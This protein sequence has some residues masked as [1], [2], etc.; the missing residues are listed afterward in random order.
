MRSAW[1]LAASIVSCAALV[2]P[3]VAQEARQIVIADGSLAEAIAALSRQTGVSIGTLGALPPIKVKGFSARLTAEQALRRILQGSGYIARPVARGAYRIER[4]PTASR[5]PARRPAP[6][7][8]PLPPPSEEVLYPDI[9]VTA[10]KREAD[11]FDLPYSISTILPGDLAGTAGHVGTGTIVAFAN[12]INKTNMGPGRNRLFI[13][14]VADSP[15]NGPSQSTVAL[16]LGDARINFDAPDPHLSLV[17]IARVEVLKGPQGPLY[18]TG[19]LGGIYRVVPRA[20]DPKATSLQL[21]TGLGLT[22]GGAISHASDVVANLPIGGSLAMRGVAYHERSGGWIDD[23][24]R[25]RENV[26]SVQI[27]GGRLALQ[28]TPMDWRFELNGAAQVLRAADS[29][30]A[31]VPQG[32]V[33]ETKVAEPHTGDFALAQAAAERDFGDV[34]LRFNAAYVRHDYTNQFDATPSSSI[35][36]GEPIQVY[37]EKRDSTLLSQE[38][39]LSESH[40]RFQWLLGVN[41]LVTDSELDWGLGS[42]PANVDKNDAYLKRHR[43]LALFGDASLD[44]APGVTASAG[45]RLFHSRTEEFERFDED[46]RHAHTTGLTPSASLAWRPDPG[47]MTWMRYSSAQRPGGLNPSAVEEPFAF[48]SDKLQSYELGVRLRRLDNRLTLEG[49]LFALTWSD[50][51]SDILLPSGLIGT[52][53]FGRA[54]NFGGEVL[55]NWRDSRI[56]A[57]AGATYQHGDIYAETSVFGRVDDAHLP[58][59]PR[60]KAHARLSVPLFTEGKTSLRTGGTAQYTDRTRLSFDPTLNRQTDSHAVFGAFV[61]FDRGNFRWT[62]SGENLTNSQAD[63]FGFGNPFSVRHIAHRTPLRPRT[64][65]LRMEWRN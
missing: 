7:P 12:G 38:L 61:Q 36:A 11:G 43:E 8:E 2:S 63:T 9:L 24:Q 46:P 17:D 42:D 20:P 5:P 28:W 27:S 15:F 54:H 48:S 59:I 65:M 16:L 1:Y 10:T 57:E 53:N 37:Q 62:L 64:V 6:R 31:A 52:A 3:A 56:A 51:Q 19:V 21:G 41:H 45:L 34:K 26:N 40:G 22:S 55:V 58:A 29:Q 47:T 39:R 50:I 35:G 23:P 33:R 60:L 44:L 32:Y 49:N 4:A 14:G 13:R 18:G 25:G 30:Y